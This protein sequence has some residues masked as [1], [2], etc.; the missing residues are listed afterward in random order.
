MKPIDLHIHTNKS[1]GE[2]SPKEVV[3]LAIKKGLRA[4]AIT[5]HDVVDGVQEAIEYAKDKDIEIIPGIEIGCDESDIGFKEVHVVGLFV[6]HKNKDLVKFT[7]GI[8]N[9]RINQKKNMIDKLQKLGYDITFEEVAKSVGGAFGRPHISKLLIEKYPEQFSSIKDVFDRYLGVGKPAYVDRGNKNTMKDAISIIK[10]AGGISF[11]AHPGV[12]K[13]EDSMEL[14]KVFKSL[15][16]NGI[17]TYYPYHII[18]PGLKIDEEENLKMIGFYQNVLKSMNLLESG[19]SDFHGSDRDTFGNVRIGRDVLERL[20]TAYY[21]MSKQQGLKGATIWFTGLACSGK[22]TLS[23]KIK[24]MLGKKGV[25]TVVLDSDELR[26]T[27]SKDFGYTKEERD[28]HMKL[29]TEMCYLL[30]LQGILNVAS[31]ISPTRSIR[32]EAKR[33]IGKFIEVYIKCPLEICKKRDVK[34]HYKAYEEG[35]LKNFVGLDIPYEEPLNADVVVE[36]D[37]YDVDACAKMIIDKMEE[38][39][40]I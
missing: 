5:D 38:K 8:K 30:T 26:S 35:K 10:K 37:K 12:Y 15:G 24:K 31:V 11:L 7:D 16:G 36:T 22:T 4:I 27:V 13:K 28:K 34:G 14:I 39:G 20:E 29:V 33:K 1:D 3:D 9:Q 18:C 32:E 2:L 40:F 19:G 6:D 17:E 25:G 21:E 23:K